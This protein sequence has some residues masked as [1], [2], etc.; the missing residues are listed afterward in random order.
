MS[1]RIQ[2][3]KIIDQQDDQSPGQ[4]MAGAMAGGLQSMELLRQDIDSIWSLGQWM[5]R[6]TY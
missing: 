2:S 6:N 3:P 5:D 4:A 1:N